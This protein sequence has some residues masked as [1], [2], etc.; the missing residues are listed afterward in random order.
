M[1]STPSSAASELPTFADIQESARL[2]E[3]HIVR[4]PLLEWP[5]LG[6]RL[7]CRLFVKPEVLQKTGSFKFRGAYNHIARL[8]P[9]TRSRGVVAYSSGNHAQG[10]AAA[11]AQLGAPAV[12]VMPADAPTIKIANTRAYGAEVVLFDRFTESREQI[13]ERIAAERGLSLI[14]PYDDR[15]II[16]GQGTI[17]LEIAVQ[18]RA[19]SVTPDAVLTPCGGG[20]LVSGCALALATESPGTAVY[21]VEP[22]GWNDTQRS[23]AA[24]KRLGNDGKGSP[25]C[26][27]L[28]A[29]MPGE[30]TFAINSRLLAGALTVGDDAVL[31]TMAAALIRLKIAV[32][33]GGAV[34]LAAVLCGAFEA[35]GKTVVVI[36]SGGN[37][38][39]AT[40][41]R[42]LDAH[43]GT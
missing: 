6:D 19:L 41:R 2:L 30:M 22:E 37:G 12:I 42:A 18:A 29:M 36:C 24:G 34:A 4:T 15:W 14:R 40:F 25:L 43:A 31:K 3:P 17:G 10:V 28:L 27:A 7:S 23:L 16:S 33:P 21:A 32:E 11:A 35:R 39:A 26:D 38:D 9:E 1:P 13:G 8:P 20:G 5:A